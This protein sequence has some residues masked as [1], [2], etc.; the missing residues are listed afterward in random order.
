MIDGNPPLDQLR[1]SQNVPSFCSYHAPFMAII[2]GGN[3]VI[4]QCCCDHWDCPR[5]S[6]IMAWQVRARAVY[7]AE[8]M[9][10]QG[11]LLYFW[12]FTCRGRD[13]DL[14]TADD[15][16]YTWTNKALSR[17]RAQAKREGKRWAY[18][19]VTE[20]QERGAAHSH[21][22]HTFCPADA[23]KTTRPDNREVY[24]SASFV[25]AVVA[26]G[27]GVQCE[28]TQVKTPGAVASYISGYLTKHATKDR[29]PKGWK[30]VRWSRDW[31]DLPTL[32]VDFTLVLR[33]HWDW[34][35]I[36]NTEVKWT[37]ENEDV[38]L[39]VAHHMACPVAVQ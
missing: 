32:D 38:A 39:Y 10:G 30:R 35:K 13:L 19:Q 16:Y 33:R 36:D 23:I 9:A 2:A 8:N 21:F 4:R 37:V 24:V 34:D 26:A 28:I 14:A 20:R 31:P 27:L 1:T 11:V 7:G 5:C 3:R 22:I 15:D 17:L 29:F 18:V 25:N 12:T 6:Q